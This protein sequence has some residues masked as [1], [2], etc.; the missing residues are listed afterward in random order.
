MPFVI[1][2]SV[3]AGWHLSGQKTAYTEAVFDL[4]ADDTA[5]APALWR[6]EFSNIVRKMLALKKITEARAW[7]ILDTQEALPICVHDEATS[8]ADNFRLAQHYGLSSYDAAY[9][10]LALR[11]SIPI[12]TRDDALY[13]AALA[14]GVGVIARQ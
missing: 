2:N 11:L 14:A 9:L 6:L 4:L 10:E 3:V 12:A 7:Q 5:H 13:E 1:D 8:I